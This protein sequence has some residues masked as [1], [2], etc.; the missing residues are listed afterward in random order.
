MRYQEDLNSCDWTNGSY[1]FKHDNTNKFIVPEAY[2]GYAIAEYGKHFE[3]GGEKS[4]H[5]IPF[6]LERAKNASDSYTKTTFK[7]LTLW[8]LMSGRSSTAR[9]AADARCRVIR[10]CLVFQKIMLDND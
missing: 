1:R 8:I 7:K 2:L 3:Q 6:I 10:L 9:R 4:Y 5:K